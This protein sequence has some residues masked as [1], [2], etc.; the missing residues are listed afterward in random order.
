MTHISF[1]RCCLILCTFILA[2]S[3]NGLKS[4]SDSGRL[5]AT[6]SSNTI[7]S[8]PVISF[9][10]DIPSELL[11]ELTI[12][13][14]EHVLMHL[15]T[16]SPTTHLDPRELE[17]LGIVAGLQDVW[18]GDKKNGTYVGK[19]NIGSVKSA[20][21]GPI[22]GLPQGTIL[23]GTAGT[24][25]FVDYIIGIDFRSQ[26][27]WFKENKDGQ[28]I[29]VEEI[30]HPNTSSGGIPI[31]AKLKAASVTEGGVLL[32]NAKFDHVGKSGTFLID[33]GANTNL[34]LSGYWSAIRAASNKK[35]PLNLQDYA[36][37][38]IHG[39][40]Q[41]SSAFLIENQHIASSAPVWVIER[42]QALQNESQHF[43]ETIDGLIGLWGLYQ[44]YTVLDFTGPSS[45]RPRI[46]LFPYE[47]SKNLDEYFTGFGIVVHKK[48]SSV[49]VAVGSDA[50]SKGVQDGDS[51]ISVSGPPYKVAPTGII[52]G[53]PGEIR[54]FTLSRKGKLLHVKLKASRLLK[55]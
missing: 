1:I 6:N 29:H 3:S 32:V 30:P 44:F 28:Q 53:E 17:T 38:P 36:G 41:M 45:F 18:L 54:D 4:Q 11:I 49:Q 31:S 19:K 15:D 9:P 10:Q 7:S 33:T 22:A 47:T 23:R 21:T 26:T 50:E 27:L 42:F 24:D 51:L 5:P 46:F 8:L 48:N 25:L 14:V 43:N 52:Y 40:Y 16:A 20:Q 37:N 35:V 13:D 55:R 2:C 12:G 39:Y 34:A